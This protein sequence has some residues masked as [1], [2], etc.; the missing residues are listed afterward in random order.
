M[1][2]AIVIALTIY[3]TSAFGQ[4]SASGS[5]SLSSASIRSIDKKINSLDDRLT[6]QTEKYLNSFAHQ[7]EKL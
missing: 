7:E 1:R 4:D 2:Y 6:R 3:C 5:I